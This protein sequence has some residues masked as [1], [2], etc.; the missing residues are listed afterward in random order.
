LKEVSIPLHISL[1]PP[2]RPCPIAGLWG[3][4]E[5]CRRQNK[6]KEMK[7]KGKSYSLYPRI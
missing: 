6:L 5:R 7:K 3:E 2:L 4:R 1:A